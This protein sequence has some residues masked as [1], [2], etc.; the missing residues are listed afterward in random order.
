MPS[1]EVAATLVVGYDRSPSSRR[2]VLRAMDLGRRLGAVLEIVHAVDL[3]DYPV[4]PDSPDWGAEVATAVGAED[5][6]VAG[7]LAGYEHPWSFRALYGDPATVLCRAADQADALMIVVGAAFHGAG[8]GMLSRMFSPSVVTRLVD[9]SGRPVLAVG[10]S[11]SPLA[12]PRGDR[13]EP[14]A[15]EPAVAE[16]AATEPAV[17]EPAATEPGTRK[18]GTSGTGPARSQ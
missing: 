10:P 17:T 8:H 13:R 9:R 18:T 11:G 3:A 12:G 14:A 4:D 2:A 16:P 5:A 1:E 15:T 6:A 7:L